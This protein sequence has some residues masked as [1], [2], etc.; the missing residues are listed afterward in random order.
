MSDHASTP[1]LDLDVVRAQFPAFDQPINRDQSFFDNAGGSYACRH[2]IDALTAYYTANKVQPY[3]EYAASADAGE[4]MDASRRRWAEALGVATNEVVFGPS[5]SINTFVLADAFAPLLGPG[6]EVIVTN[7]DHEANT[8][9]IRRMAE[10]VGATVIEWRIDPETGLL[11]PDEFRSLLSS[12]TKLVTV[13]HASNIV[14]QEND[15]AQVSAAAHAVGARV[16]VDGVSFAPHTIPDVA[17]LDADIYL[18][19]LYKT[20][21]VHQGLMVVRNGLLGELP[22]QSHFFNAD[23]P[24]KRLNPAGPDHAQVAAAGAVLDYVTDLHRAH[25]GSSDDSL[26]VMCS[27][28]SSRWRDHEDVLT[29]RLLDELGSHD[30]LRVLGPRTVDAAGGHRCPTIAFSPLDREPTDVA[31]RLVERGVQTSAGHYYAVRVL[32]GLGLDPARGVVRL[33]FVHYTSAADI[34]RACEAI[35]AE[36]G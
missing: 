32:E 8:G 28:V 2:T 12:A 30:Q 15:V 36:F 31:H 11:D 20:Y 35:A 10:R 29:G 7:Q 4:Q 6:D 22:N 33:S 14:G 26:R 24:D 21:S 13:P 3:S 1:T 25:G 34:D 16:I 9:A 5:T 17:A 23:V 19:S 27:T 18:F